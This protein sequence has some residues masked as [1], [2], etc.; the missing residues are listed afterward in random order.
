MMED[1]YWGKEF[2]KND[3]IPVINNTRAWIS[4]VTPDNSVMCQSTVT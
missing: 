1:Y 2:I 4:T 3:V